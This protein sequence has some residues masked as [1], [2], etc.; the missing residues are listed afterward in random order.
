MK[1][2]GV[3]LQLTFVLLAALLVFGFVG[4]AKEGE[5][6]RQCNAPCVLKPEYLG[7]DRTAPDFVFKDTDGKEVKLSSYRGKAVALS[8]WSKACEPC[9]DEMPELTQFS[10][11]LS[12]KNAVLIT[13]ASEETRATLSVSA[14]SEVV[15]TPEMNEREFD[16]KVKVQKA[17]LFLLTT[18][19][20]PVVFDPDGSITREKFGT[21]LFPEM[22]IIDPRGVVRARFDGTKQWTHP[23]VIQFIDEVATGVYCPVDMKSGQVTGKAAGLCNESN[24]R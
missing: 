11:L 7:A 2:Y 5:M 9:L 20:F 22:W 16:F 18:K 23:V 8:F 12:E 24:E 21:K 6:R 15:R 1:H 4:A 10:K 14:L 3:V 19:P 13:V 17:A